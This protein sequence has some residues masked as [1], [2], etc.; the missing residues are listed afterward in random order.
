MCCNNCKQEIDGGCDG[1]DA[2]MIGNGRRGDRDRD[3]EDDADDAERE[4]DAGEEGASGGGFGAWRNHL[5]GGITQRVK[6]WYWGTSP[7]VSLTI[8]QHPFSFL[9]NLLAPI[10]YLSSQPRH[11]YF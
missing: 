7:L 9:P 6:S 10:L 2:E 4:D 3:T 5:L 11:L 8:F 1:S